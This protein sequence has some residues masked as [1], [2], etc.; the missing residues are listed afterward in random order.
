[1]ARSA[2][3]RLRTHVR[4]Y[5]RLEKYVRTYV[6]AKPLATER[7]STSTAQPTS[8]RMQTHGE[9]VRIKMLVGFTSVWMRPHWWMCL[10]A[11]NTW[12]VVL[13]IASLPKWPAEATM[14]EHRSC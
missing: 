2:N 13:R 5:V 9:V 4:A 14:K 11:V 10:R 7:P 8:P 3:I 6:T 12:K 1:M